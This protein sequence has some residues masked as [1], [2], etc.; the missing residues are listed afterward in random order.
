[1]LVKC[2]RT[3]PDEQQKKDLGSYYDRY[4]AAHDSHLTLGKEYLVLGLIVNT[5]FERMA[6]GISVT[7]LCDYE[8]IESYPIVLFDVLDGSVDPEWHFRAGPEGIVVIEPV[9]L[10][11]PHFAEDHSERVPE[12]HRAFHEL[13]HRMMS[14]QSFAKEKFQ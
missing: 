14:R 2:A 5:G 12:V 10:H 9:L 6:L 3:K 11:E 4:L 13:L 7:V 1:M 8:H